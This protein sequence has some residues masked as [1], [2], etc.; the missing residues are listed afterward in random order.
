MAV[1]FQELLEAFEFVSFGQPYEHG[2]YLCR[3]SGRI[4]LHSEYTEDVDELPDD[5]EE[6]GK[7]TRVPHKNDLDLGRRLVFRFI[8]ERLPDQLDEV[9]RYFSRRGAYAR[10]KDLLVRKKALEEWYDFEN[11]A[12]EKA[13][14]EWC[15]EN[16][17]EISDEQKS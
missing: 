3:Q 13:L 14:R 8:S 1:S 5:L 15:E 12:K 2:A 11:E 9:E 10:F 7:Y 4:Y 17:I 6:P 16:S